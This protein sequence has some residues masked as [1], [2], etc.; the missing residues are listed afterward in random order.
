MKRS[1]LV[2]L[3]FAG[4][5]AAIAQE[6]MGIAHDNYAVT[7]GMLLNPSAIVDPKPFLEVN[8]VG[9][10]LFLRNNYISTNKSDLFKLQV[11]PTYDPSG[12]RMNAIGDFSLHGPSASLSWGI[13]S[14]G[15]SSQFRNYVNVR[16]MPGRIVKMAFDGIDY[17]EDDNG[18]YTQSGARLKSMGWAEFGFSYG[19]ILKQFDKDMWTGAVTVKRLIGVHSTALLTDR[20]DVEV[21]AED[22]FITHELSGK[23]AY[24]TPGWGAGKG[25]GVDIGAT[26]KRML[27]DVTKYIPHSKLAHCAKP[28]YKYKV[29]AS[30]LDV[31]GIRFNQNSVY[32]EFDRNSDIEDVGSLEDLIDANGDPEGNSYRAGLPTALSVQFDYNFENHFFVNGTALYGMPRPNNYGVERANLVAFTPRYEREYLGISMPVSFYNYTAPQVGLGLRF[33]NVVIGSDH[34][35]PWIF[36]KNMKG[37]DIYFNL[38][39]TIYNKRSCK[40]RARKLK[41]KSCPA[42]AF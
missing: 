26:Y 31:G 13:H 39:Y 1:V 42:P 14:F 27:E 5:T 19:R 22:Q 11:T 7:N 12:S 32:R 4:T 36:S 33:A 2:G 30:L 8:L 17:T 25:W 29:G 34:L 3:F 37:A 38:K 18:R 24:T 15:F 16:K 23:Y 10:S 28:D 21:L 35:L 41:T 40:S 6:N 20:S 9:A